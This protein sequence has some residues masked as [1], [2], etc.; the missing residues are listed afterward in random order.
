[1]G[2][3]DAADAREGSLLAKESSRTLVKERHG[4]RRSLAGMPE[5]RHENDPEARLLRKERCGQA[6]V[7]L[8]KKVRAETGSAMWSPK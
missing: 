4:R 6:M 2:E 8:H 1:L 5:E 3:A 7:P